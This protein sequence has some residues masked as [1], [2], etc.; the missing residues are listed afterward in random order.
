MANSGNFPVNPPD[1]DD[2][3]IQTESSRWACKFSDSDMKDAY[4]EAVV[5]VGFE[6][7]VREAA[8]SRFNAE[9]RHFWPRWVR[10]LFSG[11]ESHGV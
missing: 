11:K 9:H 5:A 4:R 1:E 8:R 6:E 3:T 10:R 7:R 2:G